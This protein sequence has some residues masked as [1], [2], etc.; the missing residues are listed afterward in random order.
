[1]PGRESDSSSVPGSPAVS[2]GAPASLLRLV[3][4]LGAI[5]ALRTR[6]SPHTGQATSPAASCRS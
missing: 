5:S 2:G 6:V 3:E 1:M 4:M